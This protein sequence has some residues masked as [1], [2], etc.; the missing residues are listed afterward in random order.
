MAFE[1]RV[2]NLGMAATNCYIIGDTETRDAVLI[3]PVDEPEL[4]LKAI[5]DEG[6][7]LRMMLATHGH[8]DHVL[9]SKGIKDATNVPFLIHRA[10]QPFLDNLPERGVQ[11]TGKPFP[12]AAVPDRY[13]SDQTETLVI[14]NI[15]LETLFTPGHAPGHV[16]FYWREANLVFSGDA[17]FRGA[18]G[19]TDLPGG[20]FETLMR[21]IFD[22]L[23]PL[24]DD[25]RV[26]P[27][28][29]EPTTIGH[30][31]KTNPFLVDYLP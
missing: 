16:A 23:V 27:G 3:D 10:D 12:A 17:L 29:G 19:R 9:A 28:H 31:R 24:G 18:I 2:F 21:A 15:V 7:I 14:G 25:T 22:K 13:L 6:W 26:L 1:I 4:L 5:T 11:W 20:D 30:E 8:F